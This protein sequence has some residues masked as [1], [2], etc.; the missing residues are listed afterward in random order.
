MLKV[1]KDV[2]DLK[3]GLFFPRVV[4]ESFERSSAE[5]GSF[6]IILE[7]DTDRVIISVAREAILGNTI[8]MSALVFSRKYT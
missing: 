3:C 8:V 1:V 6:F 4:G 7:S 2:C 5:D